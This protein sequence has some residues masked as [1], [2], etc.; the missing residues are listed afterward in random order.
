MGSK[1]N[2]GIQCPMFPPIENCLKAVQRAEQ[3]GWDFIE[4]PDQLTSTHPLGMLKPPVPQK[5]PSAPTSF[6]S[7]IWFGSFEMT[8]AAAILTDRVGLNLGVVDALRRPPSVMAQELATLSHMSAGRLTVSVGAGEVKQFEPYGLSRDQPFARMEE[9]IRIWQ[10]LWAS[11]GKPISRE[12]EFWPLKDAVFPIPLYEGKRPRLLATGGGDR[13]FR[14]AGE[15]CDGW[16]TFLPGG[17]ENNPQVMGAAI[18]RI[19]KFARE[20][21]R[22]PQELTF[23]SHPMVVLAETD[24]EAWRLARHPNVGW[25][26]ITAASIDA[27]KIWEKL[28]YKNP[29]GNFFWSKNISVTSMTKA[30]VEALTPEIPDELTDFSVIWGSPERVAKR[31]QPYI[32]AGMNEVMFVNMAACAEPEY[33]VHWERLVSEVLVRLGHAPLNLG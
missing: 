15:L 2:F 10:A 8:A 5:D 26:A 25:I 29:L 28:G 16:V 13:I 20:A 21:G 33:G 9:A 31:L 12:S 30:Q 32:D 1:I 7:E 27:G 4:Y 24:D 23:N 11:D 17:C 22:D 18:D 14:M 19:K 6:F 3:L